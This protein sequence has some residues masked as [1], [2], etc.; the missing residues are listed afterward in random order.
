MK[1]DIIITAKNTKDFDISM[2]NRNVQLTLLQFNS[3]KERNINEG[4]AN[5]PTN[6][7]RPLVSAFE[8]ILKRPA[9]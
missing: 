5:V 7:P 4:K 1:I 6:V 8:M 9:R 3:T 2:A